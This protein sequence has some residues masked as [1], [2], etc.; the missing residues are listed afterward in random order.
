MQYTHP[1]PFR[2]H[3]LGALFED[4]YQIVPR[5]LKRLLPPG[6]Q[7]LLEKAVSLRKRRRL[8]PREG[9]EGVADVAFPLTTTVQR[10]L[11]RK[12]TYGGF[13]TLACTPEEGWAGQAFLSDRGGGQGGGRH[14]DGTGPVWWREPS[15]RKVCDT[16][17]VA[18]V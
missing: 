9:G 3:L 6:G 17:V 2:R 8:L 11:G 18:R 15:R 4:L 1:F 16:S 5:F 14:V 10:Y 12:A 7:V 13:H